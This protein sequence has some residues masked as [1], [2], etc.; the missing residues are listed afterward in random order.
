MHLTN[1]SISSFNKSKHTAES[2][3][4]DEM[5]VFP[6]TGTNCRNSILFLTG[7]VARI[8]S[9]VDTGDVLSGG[10]NDSGGNVVTGL[11]GNCGVKG[12]G[13]VMAFSIT[14]SAVDFGRVALGA[15]LASEKTVLR[16][17]LLGRESILQYAE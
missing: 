14:T 15:V 12:S 9:F 7:L 10:E 1:S 5:P 2:D 11:L 4:R 17:V 8:V 6:E 3:N 16:L 13:G